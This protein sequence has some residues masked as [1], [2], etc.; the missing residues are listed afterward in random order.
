MKICIKCKIEKEL[1]E[2]YTNKS[3]KD[4]YSGKCKICTKRD[5]KIYRENNLEKV[6][7]RVN[8][9][10]ENNK[11]EA[12]EY[13]KK[14]REENSE[15]K[16]LKDKEWVDNNKERKRETNKKWREENKI[17]LREKDRIWRLENKELKKQ[18]DKLYNSNNKHKR[19][20]RHKDRIDND[21]LYSLSHCIRGSILKSF[22][23]RKITKK[24]KT[25]EILGC[26]FEEFKLYLESRFESWMTWQNRG[27]YNG[28]L[29][30]GWDIDH[31]IPVSSAETEED[32]IRLNHFSNLQPLCS[33]TNRYIKKD[34]I[35]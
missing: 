8:H 12:S 1:N 31:I 34:L 9:Y 24:S 5:V 29:N 10:R 27:L 23:E 17:I 4:G 14:W 30:Y 22:N 33:Y 26:S 32:I 11:E 20:K 3:N 18:K 7:A 16:K 25:V 6:K 2:F 35:I 15:Y 28:E 13:N 19:N 21:P